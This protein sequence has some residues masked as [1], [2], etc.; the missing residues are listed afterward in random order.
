M[1]S[2]YKADPNLVVEP[3]Y[4]S[5][6]VPVFEPTM[7]QFRDFYLYNKAIN[8][9]GMKSGIVKVVPPPEWTSLLKG[10]YNEENLLQV[11]I[12]NPIV[13]N[14]NVTAGYLGV[15]S[16]QNVERQRSYN[17]FQ[18]KELLKKHNHSPPARRKSR[19]RGSSLPAPDEKVETKEED[20][21][22][23]SK[24]G[25]TRE[26]A[27]KL[28]DADFNIDASDFTPERCSELEAAYWKS[29]GYSEPMY[30]ADM[31]GSLFLDRTTSW[32]V[33]H[34]PNVLDLMEEKIPGVNDA[35]LY[36][37]LWKAT[38]SWHLEDQDLYSI[39]YLHFGAPKQWYSIPQEESGK[40][41]DLMKEIFNEDYK[42]CHE[43]LRHKTFM[44][45]PQF[46]QKHGITCNSVVHHQGEF[47]ITYPY[48]YHSGYNLGYN[49]AESVNF[50]LDDWFP[51][52]EKTQK[53]ECISDSV[54]IN[55]KQIYCKFKGI[56]YT[57]EQ[58]EP[59][60]KQEVVTREVEEHHTP[61]KPSPR[62]REKK[63]EPKSQCVLCP[64]TL[65]EDL[66]TYHEFE[67]LGADNT[68][69]ADSKHAHRICAQQFKDQLNIH[70]KKVNGLLSI[71]KAQRGLKC[72]VC[73]VPNLTLGGDLKGACFQCSHKKCTRAFHATCAISGGVV[74][75]PALCK[76]HRQSS[77]PYYERGS[78][79]LQKKMEQIKEDSIIQF[80]F[81]N[82]TRR[83]HSGDVYAGLVQRNNVK[84][85]T[86]EILVYPN[87]RDK[88]ELQYDDILIGSS[89]KFDNQ[90][91]MAMRKKATT[92][93]RRASE[94]ANRK[95]KR[96]S[97]QE[98]TDEL[99][100]GPI[101]PTEAELTLPLKFGKFQP[102]LFNSQYETRLQQNPQMVFINQTSQRT[103]S[104]FPEPRGLRFVEETFN[105]H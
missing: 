1:E 23:T 56:P 81:T 44:A 96:S 13:Q 90:Q 31:L 4:Y 10:T 35:Y 18:W 66:L 52:A 101:S 37:G 58:P 68:G 55:Y 69:G 14:I 45:S 92:V 70:G 47:M 89:P 59:V 64:N 24:G 39:N 30:G 43:F 98:V 72:Q 22:R 20:R 102:A 82:Q 65:P 11:K 60:E 42:N 32:N 40:F 62:K 105:D 79:D 7:D 38:F 54:G 2:I 85:S 34:L 8:P 25:S 91:L 3:A 74:M 87:L 29:V 71:S 94:P 17:I 80:T 6:G 83:R 84:E 67:L 28:L 104:P 16:L 19:G 27:D 48:G 100:A 63:V 21:A 73:H 9:Y 99:L 93:R 95:R 15:F 76:M 77:S 41:Y 33:A 88:V 5:N 36:A 103:H 57:S 26:I 97:D 49:L 86:I 50:A 61:K 78:L 75:D 51:F 53:C 46:L 12:R